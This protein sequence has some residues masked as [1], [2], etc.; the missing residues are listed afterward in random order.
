M[1]IIKG[2]GRKYQERA[3]AGDQTCK[4][5]YHRRKVSK[6]E[7]FQQ[8]AFTTRG[9]ERRGEWAFLRPIDEEKKRVRNPP[10]QPQEGQSSKKCKRGGRHKF[11]GRRDYRVSSKE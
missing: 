5:V 11:V 2:P 4:K 9:G 3:F 6:K 7:L 10:H 8:R 1:S